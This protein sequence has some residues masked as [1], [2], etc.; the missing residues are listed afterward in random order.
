MKGLKIIDKEWTYHFEFEMR[1]LNCQWWNLDMAGRLLDDFIRLVQQAQCVMKATK[2][3]WLASHATH[4]LVERRRETMLVGW[5]PPREGWVKL[6]T[7]MTCKVGA[8]VGCGGVIEG[9]MES[10]L[11]ALPRG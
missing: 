10:R 7:N 11:V 6:N 2:D 9:V 5:K 1:W 4:G 8:C 3:Y